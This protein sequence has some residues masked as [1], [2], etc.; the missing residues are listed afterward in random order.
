MTRMVPE[1]AAALLL[2]ACILGAG[3]TSG[4]PQNQTTPTENQSV[5]LANPAAV[6]CGQMGYGY[7][8]RQNA[9][10]GEYGVCIFPNGTEEDAREAYRAAT[11]NSATPS[12]VFDRTANGTTV[13]LK[14]GD[15]VAIALEEN[16][17]TGYRWN[18]TV[19]AGLTILNDTYAEDEH[20]AGMVGV[21]G[22]RTWLLRADTPGD[23]TFSAMSMR[24]WENV[25]AADETFFVTFSVASA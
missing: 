14:V 20:A 7:E 13:D 3:C 8:I 10:G 24:P 15:V 12:A 1:T 23:L 5:G 18:A 2:C 11:E 19:S 6:W 22:T 25:S 9:S 17:T 16:P 4:G 21:G